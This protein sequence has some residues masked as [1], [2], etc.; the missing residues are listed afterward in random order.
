MFALSFSGAWT[1]VAASEETPPERSVGD[2]LDP[3]FPRGFQEPDGLILDV[4][5]EGR[6]LDLDGGDGVNGMCSAKGRSGDLRQSNMSEL[7]GPMTAR[8][9]RW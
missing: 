6:V 9:S 1:Y 7:P 3:E 4:Q 8:L 2:D 5:R